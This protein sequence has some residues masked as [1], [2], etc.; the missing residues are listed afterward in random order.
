MLI[1]FGA[2]AVAGVNA[3]S[4]RTS[5]P[6]SNA[7]VWNFFSDGQEARL[8]YGRP[9]SD[10]VGLML[11]CAPHSG[12]VTLSD[13][14]EPGRSTLTLVS[15]R[16]RSEIPGAATP[17]PMTGGLL[18]E[19]HAP[20][21]EPTLQAFAHGERLAVVHERGQVLMPVTRRDR[22]AVDRFFAACA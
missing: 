20:V 10:E 14:T 1:W 9:N 4:E 16:V 7:H 18:I 15:G 17:D 12:A 19:A 22:S 21:R 3:C 11:T 2:L 13:E 6:V 8:A 5:A